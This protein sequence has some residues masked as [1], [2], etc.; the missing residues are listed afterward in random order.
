MV[1]QIRLAIVWPPERQVPHMILDVVCPPVALSSN[2]ASHL[3]AAMTDHPQLS[4]LHEL[5][6]AI[7]ETA[8]FHTVAHEVLFVKRISPVA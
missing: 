4:R 8:P 1:S 5:A 7:A 2:S 3:Y 6:A